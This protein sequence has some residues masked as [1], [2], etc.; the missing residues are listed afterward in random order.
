MSNF[1]EGKI[2]KQG[3][4]FCIESKEGKNLG[5]YATREEALKRLRQIEFYKHMA[6]LADIIFATD[7]KDEDDKPGMMETEDDDEDDDED[8]V[9]AE[10]KKTKAECKCEGGMKKK[11]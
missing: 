1:T 6:N 11:C 2:V 5:C 3:S 10:C 4:K 9:C 7:D 8:E